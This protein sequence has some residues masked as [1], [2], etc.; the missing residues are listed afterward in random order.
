MV[1]ALTVLVVDLQMKLVT[2]DP[3]MTTGL[4]GVARRCFAQCLR[5]VLLSAGLLT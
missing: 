4:R 5:A 3:A 2:D 1:A